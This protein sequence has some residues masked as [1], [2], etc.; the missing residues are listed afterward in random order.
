MLVLWVDGIMFIS[1]I[2]LNINILL[3]L[4]RC[5]VKLKASVDKKKIS[6]N[7]QP[8]GKKN[9]G[10]ICISPRQTKKN[11]GAIAGFMKA[12]YSFVDFDM[13]IKLLFLMGIKSLRS[14]GSLYPLVY[15]VVLTIAVT[16][17]HA[18]DW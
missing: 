9:I 17:A 12:C 5:R 14:K 15:L 8:F 3:L 7:N 18:L 11:Y 6:E 1:T 10:I 2:T 4:S 16:I 13:F